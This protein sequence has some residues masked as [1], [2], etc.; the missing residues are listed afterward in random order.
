M[1]LSTRDYDLF[2]NFIVKSSKANCEQKVK[3]KLDLL[4]FE[5]R[6]FPSLKYIIFFF[7]IIISGKV[8]SKNRAKIAYAN[9]E[10]GRFVLAQTFCN[11]DCY[12][13][14]LTFYKTLFKNF[15][16]AGALINTCNF[17]NKKFR[18]KGV[19]VDHCGYLN[20][21]IF[22][23]F[24]L[25]KK[26]VYSNNYPHGIFCVDY[27]KNIK[28][29]LTK[30]ENALRINLK[31]NINSAQK[32][33]SEIKI[34]KLVKHATFIPYMIKV[35]YKKLE[36]IDYKSF[37]YVV[38]CHS[39]TDGQLWHGYSGFEN[40]LDWLEFTLDSL[41]KTN[42][43]ILIKPHPNFYN[44]SMA[45]ESIWD[46]K[47]YNMVLDRYKK[48][49]N[50]IFIK[51]PIHNYLLLKKLNK[52]CVL[53]S[54]FGTAILESAYMNFRSICTSHNFFDKKF[55]I[56]NMWNNKEN[57]SKLLTLNYLELKK[58]K[59]VD[60]LKLAYCMFFYYSSTYNKNHY[61]TIIERNFKLNSKSFGEKFLQKGRSLITNS[62]RGKL[63]EASRGIEV[64][65]INEIS[66]T[67]FNVKE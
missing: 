6:K 3:K 56:S 38:Y 46:E 53:L 2:Y 57:Y 32:R 5:L 44:R 51:T 8:F 22:S 37:D 52:N 10:I 36:N 21:I 26:I 20:G 67:I 41:I 15:L 4:I 54:G 17:L 25:E 55:K 9:I 35:S 47:I 11:Y 65:I 33:K 16:K 64:K 23:F 42:K 49:K 18:I 59:K 30:Y 50:L 19:Y 43:K 14:K 40:T 34:S 60:L 61:Q 45:A 66:E 63:K 7:Y 13:D 29:N 12:L 48:Y 31:K 28:K 1:F 39:F 58:P 62:Q 24:A 27:K